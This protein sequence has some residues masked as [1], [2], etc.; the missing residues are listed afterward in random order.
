MFFYSLAS[1]LAAGDADQT[2]KFFGIFCKDFFMVSISDKSSIVYNSSDV[3]YQ[4][5]GK[6]F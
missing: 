1:A 3:F 2:V 5:V 6:L 4:N